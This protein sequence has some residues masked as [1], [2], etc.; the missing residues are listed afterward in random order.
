MHNIIA[1][2]LAEFSIANPPKKKMGI[3]V[4]AFVE[5]CIFFIIALLLDYYFY[6]GNRYWDLAPHPFW[7]IIIL[8]STQYG[9]NEGLLAALISSLAL[10]LFNMPEQNIHLDLYAYAFMVM[11]KPLM[12][13]VTAVIIGE[14]RNRQFRELQNLYSMALK[15]KD[16]LVRITEAYDHLNQLKDRLESEVASQLN[17]AINL[18]QTA[19]SM[20]KLNTT[21]VLLQSR[22][23]IS[24]IL[25]PKQY[26]LYLLNDNTLQAAIQNGWEKDASYIRNFSDDSSIFQAI[27]GERKFLNITRIEG[28]M[29]LR[30]EGVMAGPLISK[31]SDAVLGM[32]KIEQLSFTQL[33][34]STVK[35]FEIICEWIGAVLQNAKQH[36]L[37]KS[38]SMVS[39]SGIYSNQFFDHSKNYIEEL[40]KLAG[41]DVTLIKLRILNPQKL[42]NDQRL[43]LPE[44]IHAATLQI[45]K[46]T[47]MMFE[48]QRRGWLF[49]LILPT[50]NQAKAELIKT[51]LLTSIHKRAVQEKIDIECQISFEAMVNQS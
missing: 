29:I 41:F 17:T 40:G 5:I 33:N 2:E 32:L 31:E 6:Q 37:L 20:E 42:S 50:A 9:T 8:I 21:Q 44:L 22:K 14:L 15:N 49:H 38:Q 19:R 12:W 39:S 1:P 35:S 24:Q 26:S 28:E 27:V 46:P 34:L 43:F 18:Y 25:D 3:N 13:F 4:S 30:E 36:Q 11:Q 10:L 7:L 23:L 51:Q 16:E 47:D 45:L 48:P